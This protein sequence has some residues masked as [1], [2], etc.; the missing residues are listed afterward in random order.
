MVSMLK[1]GGMGL[2]SALLVMRP[3]DRVSLST[4]YYPTAIFIGTSGRFLLS[5]IRPVRTL[6]F[7]ARRFTF[8]IL[9]RLC[10]DGNNG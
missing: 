3:L 7:S 8:G 6:M 5:H 2:R 4:A 9:G 10:Q 1:R